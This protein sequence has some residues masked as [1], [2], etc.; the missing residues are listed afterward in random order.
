[1]TNVIDLFPQPPEENPIAFLEAVEQ[2]LVQGHSLTR[3]SPY[4]GGFL[5]S[6]Q[7]EDWFR[8]LDRA[9]RILARIDWR[10]LAE[11]EQPSVQPVEISNDL[12]AISEKIVDT[13]VAAFEI[14]E[15]LHAKA[16]KRGLKHFPPA[17]A[18][19][20]AFDSLF[21][22]ESPV[23]YI[24]E[25]LG[26]LSP[27]APFAHPDDCWFADDERRTL[28]ST[29]LAFVVEDVLVPLILL[30]AKTDKPAQELSEKDMRQHLNRMLLIVLAMG[31]PQL[32]TG[33]LSKFELSKVEFPNLA[34]EPVDSSLASL[35]QQIDSAAGFLALML[36]PGVFP[37]PQGLLVALVRRF[38]DEDEYYSGDEL[39]GRIGLHLMNWPIGVP[40][41]SWEEIESGLIYPKWVGE[42]RAQYSSPK[43]VPFLPCRMLATWL[44]PL[45]DNAVALSDLSDRLGQQIYPRMLAIYSEKLDRLSISTLGR[46]FPWPASS[47]GNW[48]YH[49]GGGEPSESWNLLLLL[50]V[51][52]EEEGLGYS[53]VF[54]DDPGEPL[55][56]FYIFVC[57]W[58]AANRGGFPKLGNALFSFYLIRKLIFG[59]Q[60]DSPPEFAAEPLRAQ[61]DLCLRHPGREWVIRSLGICRQTCEEKGW[62]IDWLRLDSLVDEENTVP[63]NTSEALARAVDPIVE[64]G[65]EKEQVMANE[66]GPQWSR[67]SKRVRSMLSH[68]EAQFE[69]IA[70]HLGR[71]T[72][73]Y[74]GMVID[75]AICFE[76]ELESRLK[77]LFLEADVQS[78]LAQN[79]SGYR[80]VKT[81]P[82]LGSY[83]ML[84][85]K[86][87]GMPDELKERVTGCVGSLAED[88]HLRGQLRELKKDSRDKGAHSKPTPASDFTRVRELIFSEG[89]LR[90]FLSA[91]PDRLEK[92]KD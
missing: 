4:I 17:Y 85:D 44:H 70:P 42:L 5:A 75:Y 15:E 51:A 25:A 86:F 91:L 81:E 78:F 62:K 33:K 14:Q 7:Q 28:D 72:R 27:E 8:V 76:I 26:I 65:Y 57:L 88:S 71:H 39:G 66:Y 45:Y 46:R 41:T 36:R 90:S 73:E 58:T 29:Q 53:C 13:F 47:P 34:D 50:A 40:Q 11:K 61:I 31:L 69:R 68:A 16:A 32:F 87:R 74:K 48:Y 30:H 84:L 21:G 54:G 92:S 38:L 1:M 63:T 79:V 43:E 18:Y 55:S 3:F 59:L 52:N 37:L 20:D 83:L 49:G 10:P 19:L 77:G 2:S 67:L 80:T 56:S 12:Q 9:C 6:V 64:L 24:E 35:L 23:D 89:L 22:N 82:T 60:T